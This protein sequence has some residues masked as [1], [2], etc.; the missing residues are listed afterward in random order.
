MTADYVCWK[1][2]IDIL[3]VVKM[4]L[5]VSETPVF[6]CKSK[7]YYSPENQQWHDEDYMYTIPTSSF[8]QK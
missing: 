8:C 7:K 5:L 2:K 4:S 1:F 6:I 3:T